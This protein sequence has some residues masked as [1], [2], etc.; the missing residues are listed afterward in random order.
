MAVLEHR[1]GAGVEVIAAMGAGVSRALLKA[2]E[3][4]VD[5]AALAARV[6]QSVADAHHVFEAGVVR[7]EAV[8]E[9]A[10]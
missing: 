10:D 5:H 3:G 4:G 9:L 6:A 8:E 7:G 2:V 1:P